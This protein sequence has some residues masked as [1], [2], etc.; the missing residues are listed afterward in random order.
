MVAASTG[1]QSGS[2]YAPSAGGRRAHRKARKLQ[3]SLIVYDNWLI[4]DN[5]FQT[6][7]FI[8]EVNIQ[9]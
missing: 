5:M 4:I 6:C 8:I 1:I 9:H 2:G 3:D 7:A